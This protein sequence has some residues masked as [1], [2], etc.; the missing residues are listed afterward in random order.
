M[1]AV[2]VGGEN[3]SS[4]KAG[5]QMGRA[6]VPSRGKSQRQGCESGTSLA[7][8]RGREEA[9][10]SQR[11][12]CL[13]SQVSLDGGALGP[14]LVFERVSWAVA[15]KRT[16]AE[17]EGPLAQLRAE[18]RRKGWVWLAVDR[19]ADGC[20]GEGAEKSQLTA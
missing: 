16:T 7:C 4:G 14:D 12:N 17:Q 2:T 6:N 10:A 13:R 9:A 20:E 1:E 5:G 19:T 11:T 8:V 15:G 18:V 3:G